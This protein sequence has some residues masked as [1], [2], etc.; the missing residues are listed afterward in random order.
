MDLR[1]ETVLLLAKALSP[2]YLRVGGTMADFLFFNDTETRVNHSK[3]SKYA[4]VDMSEYCCE[5]K[6]KPVN[7]TMTAELWNQLNEFV[8]ATGWEMIF[9]L[10]VLIRKNGHW[11]PSNAISLLK[12]SAS[13]GYKITGF[14]LGNGE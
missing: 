13:K 12:Y 5:R 14:E 4:T 9:D 7:F 6:E 8:E 3:P 11:D 1:S 10:N 2:C